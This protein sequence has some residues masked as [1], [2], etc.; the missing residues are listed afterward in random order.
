MYPNLNEDIY[1]IL[2]FTIMDFSDNNSI[3]TAVHLHN[4]LK[5]I[6]QIETCNV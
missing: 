4:H 1:I 3:T 2:D 6:M 5:M